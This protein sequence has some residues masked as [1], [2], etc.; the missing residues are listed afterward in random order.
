MQRRKQRSPGHVTTSLDG[1]ERDTSIY[2]Q[3]ELRISSLTYNVTRRRGASRTEKRAGK[4]ARARAF[5]SHVRTLPGS[6]STAVCV[7][8]GGERRIG[9]PRDNGA[10]KQV[11][12]V[13]NGRDLFRTTY[14]ETDEGGSARRV[15][16][17]TERNG[18]EWNGDWTV[19]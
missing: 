15:R 14:F 7:G 8:G 13:S 9:A 18:T 2:A 19:M 6:T 5:I 11:N 17:G 16:P 12:A 1:R 4:I 3:L 10:E